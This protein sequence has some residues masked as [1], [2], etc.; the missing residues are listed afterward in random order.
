MKALT[1]DFVIG[2]HRSETPIT[3]SE[4]NLFIKI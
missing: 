3:F 4:Q 2:D 1:L